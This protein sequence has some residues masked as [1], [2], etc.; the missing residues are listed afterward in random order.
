[1]CA[2][3]DSGFALAAELRKHMKK[4]HI[5]RMVN[6]V[7]QSIPTDKN[8]NYNQFECYIC[9]MRLNNI[10]EVK[11]HLKQ[12]IAA[13]DKKCVIC[14]EYLTVNELNEHICHHK[15]KLTCGY[16]DRTFDVTSELLKH[17]E[18]DHEERILYQCRKCSQFYDTIELRRLHEKTHMVELKP[19]SCKICLKGFN[20]KNSLKMHAHVHSDQS[21]FIV[22][23]MTLLKF[24]K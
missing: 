20:D 16:C 4:V 3:C 14:N 18:N 22:F 10:S 23:T 13:R 7:Y 9:K 17:L 15:K 6:L 11:R 2:L 8:S 24:S 21:K 1:M 19:F 12:H 5:D